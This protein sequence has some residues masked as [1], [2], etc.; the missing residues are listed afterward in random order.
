MDGWTDGSQSHVSLNL[1]FSERFLNGFHGNLYNIF[2]GQSELL[3]L[4]NTNLFVIS[5][6][7]VG[8][9]EMD[10]SLIKQMNQEIQTLLFN[11]CRLKIAF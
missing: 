9:W 7:S 11:W 4:S 5:T 1:C 8:L 6:V 10:F 2:Y 3:S